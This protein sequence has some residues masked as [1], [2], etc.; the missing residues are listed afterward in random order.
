MNTLKEA[1][2]LFDNPEKKH[3]HYL[4]V[5]NT[6]AQLPEEI[7]ASFEAQAEYLAMAFQDNTG[8]KHWNTYL[9]PMTTWVRT[10][11]GEEVLRPDISSIKPNHI[12]YWENRASETAN[13]LMLMRYT[14]LVLDFKKKVTGD[15]PDYRT[16]ILPYIEAVIKCVE[17]D[18]VAYEVEGY[19]KMERALQMSASINNTQLFEKAQQVLW[20]YDHK[21]GKDES[22]GLWGR[23]FKI[24]I[25]YLERYGRF[26]EAL[27][28]ENEARFNR[29]ESQALLDGGKTDHFAH[30]LAE[31]TDL[32]CEY[33]NKKGDNIK[34]KEYLDRELVVIKKSFDLRGGM[35]AHAMLQIM[36]SKYRKYHFY[37]EA[38][39]LYIDIQDWGKKALA[40]MQGHEF[41]VPIDNEQL[42][43]YLKD[44][45]SG[46]PKEVFVK[47]LV[48]NIPNQDMERQRQKEEAEQ[49]P[50]LDMIRTTTYDINGS[51][52]NNVGV[53]EDSEYQKL[54]YGMYRRMLINAMFLRLEVTKMIGQGKL[55][56]EIVLDAFKDS[57]LIA[58]EQYGLFERGM[59]AYFEE[60]YIVA[61]HLLIPQFES[62]IRRM[63]SMCGGEIL[64]SDRDPKDG[65]R[66][67]SL[68]GLLDSE[69]A[70]NSLKEDIQTYFKNLFT[71]HNGWNLRNRISHGLL[72][73]SG[74][75]STIA[76][77][78]VHAFGLLSLLEFTE[79]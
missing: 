61:C 16:I 17:D 43:V 36:Q 20:D 34:I 38:N 63:V 74:F 66:Y 28:K 75:N 62:A 22:P 79:K 55:S 40:D 51:P 18:Y 30:I 64:Q 76:D 57:P 37:K 47:Y 44:F 8:E 4:D 33:Y 73:T 21:H 27:V 3:F 13:P 6:I 69:E 24:M 65:N 9:G 10:D 45:L 39:N 52:I 67:I 53:G 25:T 11:T 71:E 68:D 77:R 7:T 31:E 50:L 15:K 59:K 23:H 26:E 2:L 48:R 19:L 5:S 32:L 35:W 60:D 54:M 78:I 14:G 42:E 12:S 70:K 29:I 49:Y 1:L 46:T 58:E 56:L 41:S 72:Q